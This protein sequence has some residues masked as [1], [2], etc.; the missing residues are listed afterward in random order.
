MGTSLF[1]YI[2]WKTSQGREQIGRSMNLGKILLILV[3]GLINKASTKNVRHDLAPLELNGDLKN[4]LDQTELK[5]Y[6]VDRWGWG[7]IE[8]KINDAKGW[9][10]WKK[11]QIWDLVEEAKGI[12]DWIASKAE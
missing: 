12:K 2:H 11:G 1:K 8:D 3:L 5:K 6:P 7:W 10:E 4:N 9:I